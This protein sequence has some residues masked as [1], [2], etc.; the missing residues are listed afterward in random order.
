MTSKV[1]IIGPATVEGADIDYLFAQVRTDRQYVD[2]SP[3][4]G[5]MLAAVGPLRSKQ[6]LLPLIGTIQWCASTM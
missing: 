4:C 1:A 2:Y 5:N 6:G 3:N